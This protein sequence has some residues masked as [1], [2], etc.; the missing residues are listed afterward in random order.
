M[1]YQ[2][3]EEYTDDSRNNTDKPDEFQTII[4]NGINHGIRNVGGIRLVND[5][6]GN[7]KFIVLVDNPREDGQYINDVNLELGEIVYKGDNKASK[8]DSKVNNPAVV[9]AMKTHAS[10][11][12][13]RRRE[14]PPILYFRTKPSNKTATGL[15]KLVFKG[16]CHV[17]DSKD[18]YTRDDGGVA[19]NKQFH[20]KI[21]DTLEIDTEW[22]KE[23]TV[24]GTHQHAPEVWRKWIQTGKV[25]RFDLDKDYTETKISQR[26]KELIEQVKNKVTDEDAFEKLVVKLFNDTNFNLKKTRSNSDGGYDAHGTRNGTYFTKSVKVEAKFYKGDNKVGRETG[27]F[28]VDRGDE[29]YFVTTTGFTSSARDRINNPNMEFIDKN[30]LANM[31]LE[32]SLTEKFRLKKEVLDEVNS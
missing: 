18:I 20:L 30:K 26:K 7:T 29:A 10:D 5:T 16:V 14:A 32:S 3:D 4:N 6:D 8:P 27:L 13:E 15:D 25:S 22:I 11:K 12:K 24:H 28:N 23:F 21:L 2:I 17:E 1:K 19:K 31:L 9:K